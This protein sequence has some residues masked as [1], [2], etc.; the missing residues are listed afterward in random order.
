MATRSSCHWLR[1]VWAARSSICRSDTEPPCASVDEK[2][3]LPRMLLPAR[4]TSHPYRAHEVVRRGAVALVSVELRVDVASR[5]CVRV[6][7]S[8]Y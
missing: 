3:A 4:Y 2:S 5:V 8:A 6:W 1:P 7:D